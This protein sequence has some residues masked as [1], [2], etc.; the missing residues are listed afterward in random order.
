MQVVSYVHLL[1]L[2]CRTWTVKNLFWE[3]VK[4]PYCF[5]ILFN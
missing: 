4:S 2:L 5:E 3:F 1:V